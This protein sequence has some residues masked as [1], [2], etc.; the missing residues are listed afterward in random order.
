VKRRDGDRRCGVAADGFQDLDLGLHPDFMHLL[1]DEKSV[2]VVRDD[3]RGTRA[4]ETPHPQHRVL[5]QGSIG[6]ERQ[7]LLGQKPPRH[8]PQA[9]A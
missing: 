8:R 7:K 3:D 5:K 9:G 1:C 6:N 4:V 2:L